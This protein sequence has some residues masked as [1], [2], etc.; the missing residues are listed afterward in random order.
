MPQGNDENFARKCY[1]HLK[2]HG[3]FS[4]TNK[5][6][7]RSQFTVNHYAG[8]VV[9]TTSSFCEKNKD[10][11]SE[12]AIE[13]IKRSDQPVIQAATQ[14]SASSDTEDLPKYTEAAI[15]DAENKGALKKGTLSAMIG[16]KSGSSKPKTKK[17]RMMADTL[18]TQ[19][20]QQL[21]M[22]MTIVRATSPH[23][24]RCLKPNSESQP[25]IIERDS[26]V[27]QLRCG[28]VLEAV[29]VSRAGYPVRFPHDVFLIKYRAVVFAFRQLLTEK[30]D[31]DNQISRL[32]SE[33]K[34]MVQN[35]A[36]YLSSC[37]PFSV[38]SAS[39]VSDISSC[40]VKILRGS[41]RTVMK[42]I[43]LQKLE[44]RE[45]IGKKAYGISH[46]ASGMILHTL[47]NASQRIVKNN[48]K[49][50]EVSDSNV[51]E[52][53]ETA[54]EENDI[55]VGKTKVFFRQSAYEFLENIR[56]SVLSGA[57]IEIQRIVRGHL[58]FSYVRKYKDSI[59]RL[60]CAIRCALARSKTRELRRRKAA[61]MVQKT[62]RGC[63]CRIQYHRKRYVLV[64]L[65][66]LYRGWKAREYYQ[67]LLLNIRASQIIA[68]YK[69]RQE[70]RRFVHRRKS[71]VAVQTAIR[72]YLAKKKLKQLREEARSL[73]AQQAK[74]EEMKSEID[75]LRVRVAE[76]E[77][78]RSEEAKAADGTFISREDKD[79][80][81]QVISQLVGAIK[82]NFGDDEQPLETVR[83][84]PPPEGSLFAPT[85][86]PVKEQCQYFKEFTLPLGNSKSP[87]ST[88]TKLLSPADVEKRLSASQDRWKNHQEKQDKEVAKLQKKLLD[89][90]RENDKLKKQLS[91]RW[92]HHNRIPEDD[93]EG[94][95]NQRF[96]FDE[97]MMSASSSSE[98][99][100]SSSISE[101]DRVKGERFGFTPQTARCRRTVRRPLNRKIPFVRTDEVLKK[102][103]EEKQTEFTNEAHNSSLPPDADFSDQE[104]DSPASEEPKQKN[105]TSFMKKT[106]H[107][108]F[109]TKTK[110]GQNRKGFRTSSS[111]SDHGETRNVQQTHGISSHG[112]PMLY[113]VNPDKNLQQAVNHSQL[114]EEIESLRKVNQDLVEVSSLGYII[115]IIVSIESSLFIFT[116][117][118]SVRTANDV[119]ELNRENDALRSR[120]HDLQNQILALQKGKK[121]KVNNSSMQVFFYF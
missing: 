66:S 84:Q 46:W 115:W 48:K 114:R 121:E 58:A 27:S 74:N 80:V 62:L 87:T 92:T 4:V 111:G 101:G 79:W 94:H 85:F 25:R 43:L 1:E 23:Y 88:S 30:S 76:L 78:E 68:F 21:K 51:D 17:S 34:Y 64:Q 71:A 37:N 5:Q 109:S 50:A 100:R 12:E 6:K 110:E 29:R 95:S 97:S 112:S 65:Q 22:L 40:F 36:E 89:L 20:R 99:K 77:N 73:K 54:V 38:N 39:N 103:D 47:C 8:N 91:S 45:N 106:F 2:E 3:R 49:L 98:N 44:E 35:E 55:Q 10:T 31:C 15:R 16:E 9:Y 56:N 90:S 41:R 7:A 93:G 102:A 11:I 24:I 82:S 120:N 28:G 59:I 113:H 96:S 118:R 53:L 105:L 104:Q 33:A 75:R 42:T 86:E 69:G 19:F 108:L 13:L 26:L 52:H 61:L 107:N 57:C 116:L 81:Q 60:Q 18:G 14:I 63:A 67:Q 72:S 70:R 119:N 83:L 32:L 117:Q